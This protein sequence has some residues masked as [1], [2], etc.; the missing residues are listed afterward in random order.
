MRHYRQGVDANLQRAMAAYGL[1]NLQPK[2]DSALVRRFGPVA[3]RIVSLEPPKL[4]LVLNDSPAD[5]PELIGVT[6]ERGP[7]G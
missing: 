2:E 4:K 3:L 1:G 7:E 6:L 5:D